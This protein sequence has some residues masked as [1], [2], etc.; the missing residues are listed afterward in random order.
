MRA[1]QRIFV[2][3]C[4]GLIA[5][6]L[7]GS[8]LLFERDPWKERAVSPTVPKISQSGDS[9]C[10]DGFI[11][12]ELPGL[13]AHVA[14][15]AP[16][17]HGRMAAVWYAG[18]REG[19]SDVAIFLAEFDGRQWQTPRLLVD[20][21]S[22]SR[23]TAMRVKKIGNPVI[24]RDLESRLWLVYSSV[25][26]GGWSTTSLN[27]QIS[28]DSGKTWT[29]SRKLFLSPLFNLT[30]NVKNKA[31]LL[32]DGSFLLPVYHELLTKRSALVHVK[33]DA[34]KVTYEIRRMTFQGK[35]IQPALLSLGGRRLM[36][37]FRNMDG[38]H[39]L[40]AES[41]DMG[42][43]WSIP[44][45]LELPN[46]NAGFDVIRL[47]AGTLLAAINNSFE[48][49][50][51]LSLAISDDEG[52]SWQIAHRLQHQP[53]NEYSYPSLAIDDLGLIH[54]VY[55]YERK[56]IKHMV[57]NEAWLRETTR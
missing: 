4:L 51:D 47:D 57:F 22:C 18:S 11:H 34:E 35:A 8:A 20:R 46:P 40:A 50:S 31:I 54:L 37:L 5:T 7:F 25:F 10:R 49:R 56:S 12:D 36:A 33:L 9:F 19:A 13:M 15:I 23:D 27:Y 2:K 43:A 48:D 39:V 26:E 45:P 53:G 29:P 24:F 17:A 30:Y 6:I 44:R 14:S 1:S 3:T 21:Q 52:A 32:D 42:C 41:D 55:T 28:S 16:L 38:G